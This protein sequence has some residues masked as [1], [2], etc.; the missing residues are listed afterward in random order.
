MTNHKEILKLKSPGLSNSE[1]AS[2]CGC[3]RNTVT[4]VLQKAAETCLAWAEVGVII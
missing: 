1:V 4:G 2:S 3:G